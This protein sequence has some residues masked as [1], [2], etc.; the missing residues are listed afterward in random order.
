MLSTS[1]TEGLDVDVSRAA[2]RRSRASTL[3]A[4]A[5]WLVS[6]LLLAYP[7][8]TT[9]LGAVAVALGRA[10][11]VRYAATLALFAVLT[12]LVDGG[13]LALAFRWA[14]G[15]GSYRDLVRA[16]GASYLLTIVSAFVGLGGLVAYMKR[17][18]GVG[19]ERGTGVALMEL[20]HEVGALGTWA[21]LGLLWI[22][23]TAP[24]LLPFVAPARS[25]GYGAMLFFVACFALSRVPLSRLPLAR[26]PGD[27]KLHRILSVFRDIS[28]LRFFTLYLVKLVQ[29]AIHGVFV[30]LS[31]VSF[32][33]LA[34]ETAG[35]ALSQIVRMVRG[36]PVSAFG[37]GVDQLTFAVLFEPWDQTG[38]RILAF[39]LVYTFSMVVA[40]GLLGL[41]FLRGVV[42]AWRNS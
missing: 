38:V 33:I 35:F 15:A 37:I 36:L 24:E 19:Y 5:P 28:T 30:A 17:V 23:H 39:S 20:L 14:C 32:G 8:A 9:D 11:F 21:V 31:L 34:P 12:L 1:A 41:C 7:F 42:G 25:F 3:K 40:R 29:N 6:A 4:V 10:D 16:R 27:G 22:E 2:V 18:H 13:Y 26:G